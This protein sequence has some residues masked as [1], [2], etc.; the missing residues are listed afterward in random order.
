MLSIGKRNRGAHAWVAT[1]ATPSIISRVGQIKDSK[2]SL[3]DI[4][5][6][7]GETRANSMLFGISRMEIKRVVVVV[8]IT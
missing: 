3:S 8:M 7:T 6:V 1:G 4:S 5:F 2:H